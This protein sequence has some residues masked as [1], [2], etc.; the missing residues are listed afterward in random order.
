MY[1]N[2]T[3]IWM[4]KYVWADLVKYLKQYR[5]TAWY[6]VPSI[7]LRISKS[8]EITREDLSGLEGVSTGAAP[9][10]GVLMQ[11]VNRKVG[12]G[13]EKLIGQTW[14]LSETTGA[15]TAPL[16]DDPR[17][18]DDT[19][20]I[21]YI[22]PSVELRVVDDEGV[23]VEDAEKQ[24]GEM[25]I[26]SPLVTRGYWRNPEATKSAFID[27]WFCSG[28]VGIMKNGKFY[29][30]DRKKVRRRGGPFRRERLT[31]DV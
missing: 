26:R 16:K 29:V 6:T 31:D 17:G 30:V 10:D 4:R 3:V 12:N 20:C 27:G 11:N 1:A 5:I 14:G 22:L 21:G 7:W 2:A 18:P 9:M 8:D 28:D 15:V 19:G 23:D 25:L 24:E 13:N